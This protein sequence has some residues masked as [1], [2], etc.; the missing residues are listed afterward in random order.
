MPVTTEVLDCS[1]SGEEL[2]CWAGYVGSVGVTPFHLSLVFVSAHVL[3][4][5]RVILLALVLQLFTLL[6]FPF[7]HPG[8]VLVFSVG[9]AAHPLLTHVVNRP[10]MM[11]MTTNARFCGVRVHSYRGD[12]VNGLEFTE[13]ARRNDPYRMVSAYHQSAQASD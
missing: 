2:S 1:R 8:F 10:T 12:I 4:I 3:C 5:L 11:T 6:S 7:L 13:N 9:V